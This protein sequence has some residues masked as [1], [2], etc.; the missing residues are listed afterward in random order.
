ML[1]GV[2]RDAVQEAE[3]LLHAP[4]ERLV[5]LGRALGEVAEH[6]QGDAHPGRVVTVLPVHA[7]VGVDLRPERLRLLVRGEGQDRPPER[8]VPG[9]RSLADRG[10]PAG[11][12]IL[13]RLRPDARLAPLEERASA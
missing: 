3:V 11:D 13:H 8:P 2:D 6:G 7:P 5:G 12:R 9:E 4:L 1:L 10:A